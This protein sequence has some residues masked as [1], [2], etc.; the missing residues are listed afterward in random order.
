VVEHPAGRPDDDL[1]A[2]LK[3]LELPFD[4]LTA[5]DREDVETP[6]VLRQA[7]ELLGGL[8]GEF[9]GGGEDED[10]RRPAVGVDPL[11]RRDGERRCLSRP[12]LGLAVTSRPS[13]IAGIVLIWMGVGSSK[14][15][16]SIGPERFL[17][18]IEVLEGGTVLHSSTSWC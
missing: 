12:G 11:D 16:S 2:A 15:I 9:A 5:V 10:L 1:D 7:G 13:S 8:D 18:D 4:R 17:R 3:A 14:P 6:V